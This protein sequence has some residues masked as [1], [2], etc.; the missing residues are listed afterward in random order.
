MS[1]ARKVQIVRSKAVPET[2]SLIADGLHDVADAMRM[3][4]GVLA[5]G[6]AEQHSDTHGRQKEMAA[7][8][9]RFAME[10]YFSTKV[11]GVRVS[12]ADQEQAE[13]MFCKLFPQAKT[14][15]R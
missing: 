6:A 3:I 1:S 10:G 12:Q 11:D 13:A 5:W 15:R 9:L 4:A 7:V 8:I 14:R 2:A